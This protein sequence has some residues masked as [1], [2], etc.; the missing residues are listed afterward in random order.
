MFETYL[1]VE[2]SDCVKDEGI[3]LRECLKV[4]KQVSSRFFFL[5]K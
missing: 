4:E 1:K 3:F 2:Y 5:K